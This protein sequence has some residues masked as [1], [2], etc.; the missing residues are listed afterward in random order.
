[1]AS[2]LQVPEDVRPF[3]QEALARRKTAEQARVWAR[4][5]RW[6]PILVVL[7]ATLLVLSYFS[8][9]KFVRIL[10][11]RP[12]E[13]TIQQPVQMG[14]AEGLRQNQGQRQ[15]LSSPVDAPGRAEGV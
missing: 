13:S 6:T 4:V 14:P 7:W 2:I 10:H 11:Q 9:R 5:R 3:V 15:V 1:V 8:V 12:A